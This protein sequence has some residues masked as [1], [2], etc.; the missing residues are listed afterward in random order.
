MAALDEIL[1]GYEALR[2]AT[3]TVYRR[4]P[5]VRPAGPARPG[6]LAGS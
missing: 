3:S 6:A 5:S 1:A 4:R 2:P